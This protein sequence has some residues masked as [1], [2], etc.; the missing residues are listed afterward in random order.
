MARNQLAVTG[1]VIL[2]ECWVRHR[3]TTASATE[4]G[5]AEDWMETAVGIALFLFCA[6]AA[7]S[8]PIFGYND[9]VDIPPPAQSEPRGR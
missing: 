2:V 3:H 4:I 8:C 7:V 6:I 5:S 9:R 1:I